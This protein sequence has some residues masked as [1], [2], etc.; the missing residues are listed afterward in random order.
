M[1][2][3]KSEFSFH[4]SDI[5]NRKA[6]FADSVYIARG[7][8][9]PYKV[10]P[11]VTGVVGGVIRLQVKD[12]SVECPPVPGS[13]YDALSFINEDGKAYIMVLL[14]KDAEPIAQAK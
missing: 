2:T 11:G 5:A 12:Q 14:L 13:H 3:K 4:D 9:G 7:A 8:T 10:C 1:I 6:Q